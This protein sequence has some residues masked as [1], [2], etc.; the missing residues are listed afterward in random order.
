MT[1]FSGAEAIVKAGDAN[2]SD[3][4]LFCGICGWETSSFYREMHEEGLWRIVSSDGGTIL[5]ELNLLRCEEEEEA[6]EEICDVDS[7]SRNAGIHTWEMLMDM[8]GRGAEARASADSFG[9]LMLREWA[10]GTLSFS[11]NEGQSNMISEWSVAADGQNNIDNDGA[12]FD[13]AQYDPAT[14]MTAP[15]VET[16]KQQLTRTDS[17][18]GTLIRA[19]SASRSPFL[20]SDQGYHKSLILILRDDD[21]CSEGVIL[22]HVT[23]SS[24]SLDMGNE[25]FT[26]LPVRY[27]GPVQDYGEDEMLPLTFL[28]SNNQLAEA[29]IG[30]LVGNRI[31]QCTEDETIRAISLGLASPN[32]FMVI[33]GISVWKKYRVDDDEVVG[34]VLGDIEEGFFE[35]VHQNLLK[36]IWG[37]LLDQKKLSYGTAKENLSL[38]QQSWHLAGGL[39]ADEEDRIQVFGSDQDVSELADEALR[40]WVKAYLIDE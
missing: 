21:E 2:P 28:H 14:S 31:F 27:G 12:L 40:R 35:P 13:I 26:E 33:Q 29:G 32:T 19:S 1:S 9:D 6:A 20:L 34:G 30:D 16:L 38:T 3:F 4:W 7:D 25:K 18:A 17:A 10:T 23:D 22:N 36:S 15:G 8:I 24:Y 37:I 5:E 39:D 11:L